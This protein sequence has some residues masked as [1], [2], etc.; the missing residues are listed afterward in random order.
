LA[1]KA[2][3]VAVCAGTAFLLAFGHY[4]HR[5]YVSVV[6]DEGSLRLLD[7]G[8]HLR[9]PWHRV[10]TY[11]IQCREVRVQIFE[12][13]PDVKIHFDGVLYVGIAPDSVVSLHRAYRG[14]YMEKVI[15]PAI[16]GFLRDTGE[17]Y[18]LW[19]EDVPLQR[20]TAVMLGLLGTEGGKY[21]INVTHIWLRSYE[22]ERT[23]RTF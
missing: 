8:F 23:A 10:T 16:S 22:V 12:E 14:A 15:S 21:G 9:A 19:E 2:I 13:G 7:H 4:T 18:G 5:G 17:A 6:D 11:P 1:R 20:V 3:I